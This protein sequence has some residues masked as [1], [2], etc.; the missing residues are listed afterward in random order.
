MVSLASNETIRNGML[1]GIYTTTIYGEI[2]TIFL[3]DGILKSAWDIF[4]K[5]G[6]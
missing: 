5:G 6:K 4:N 2:I 1:D 3:E